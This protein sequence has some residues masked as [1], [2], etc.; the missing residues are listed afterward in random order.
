MFNGKVSVV[1]PLC[2]LAVMCY[3]VFKE[4]VMDVKKNKKE[5]LK[6]KLKTQQLTMHD[7]GR[8]IHDNVGQKLTL[9]SLYLQQMNS[10][11]FSQQ[12]EE[13]LQTINEILNNSLTELR[14]LSRSLVNTNKSETDLIP[15]LQQE[16]ER[17]NALNILK[18]TLQ[19]NNTSF[20][21]PTQQIN[22]I[23]RI[24]QEVFQNIIK[25]ASA[26]NIYLNLQ[27]SQAQT[28]LT[29]ADDGK[30]FDTTQNKQYQG[31]GLKNMQK[32]ASL[33]NAQLQ[34]TSTPGQGTSIQII[35]P[36]E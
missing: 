24:V 22:A 31:I 11:R 13:R 18:L 10:P 29:I 16:I 30:G 32:R 20:L 14:S 25:H 3:F 19:T 28:T 6:N 35:I 15:L 4:A 27:T 17:I 23:Y 5:L 21:K 7:I 34:L 12:E 1:Y 33:I 9:A 26:K 36:N 8:E 2:K